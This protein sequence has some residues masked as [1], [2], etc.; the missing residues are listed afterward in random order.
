MKI[1]KPVILLLVFL[2]VAYGQAQDKSSIDQAITLSQSASHLR[3]LASDELRGRDTG[4]PEINIA[5]RYIAESFRQSGLRP[6]PG[7]DGFFQ[8]MRLVKSY[9]PKDGQLTLDNTSFQQGKG[10][11]VMRGSGVDLNT[12]IVFANYGLEADLKDLSLTGKILVVKAGSENEK[13]PR[14]FLGLIKTKQELAKAKGAVA[15]IELYNSPGVPWPMLINFFN[16]PQLI[17][18][19]GDKDE[20]PYLWLQDVKNEQLVAFKEKKIK[21]ATLVISDLIK[22][23]L[24]SKNVLGMIEGTDPK[25]KN[26]YLLL[27]AHYDH[28]GVRQSNNPNDSI[29]NGARDNAI[30]T[31]AVLSAASVLGKKP[32]SRSV[33][34]A[35]WTAE[36][37]GL[38]GSAY[39]A[40]HPLIPLNQTIYNLN[41]DGAGY[42]DTTLITVIGLHRTSA[43]QHIVEAAQQYGLTALADP[44]PEQGLFDRSDNVNFARKGIPAPTYSTGF[45]AFDQEIMKYYHQVADEPDGLNFNYL[46]KYFR[47][48]TLTAIKIANDKNRPFWVKGDKYEEAGKAL[49]GR[50]KAD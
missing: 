6:L 16:Q 46:L 33:I 17:I 12:E 27:S 48:Y 3:F 13:D 9:P 37:K 5:A 34:F 39:Y 1:L 15:V 22:K 14:Q 18:D 10:L 38:L 23:P 2:P 49:Y 21:K 29:F 7:A 30:G 25:L 44:A 24:P 50:K 19:E 35:A 43:E 36:E 45:T 20:L 28:V 47:A 4:S 41:I 42:N 32:P 26:E 8:N 31:V 11:L 40:D